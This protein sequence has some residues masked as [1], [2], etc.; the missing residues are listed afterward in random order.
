M[1]SKTA[2]YIEI[3]WTEKGNTSDGSSQEID[4][5]MK[6]VKQCWTGTLLL[7]LSVSLQTKL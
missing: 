6:K 7:P 1:G 4:A 2:L 3:V 5:V